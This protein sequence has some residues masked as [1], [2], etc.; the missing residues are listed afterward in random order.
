MKPV[1]KKI[2]Q[3]SILTVLLAYVGCIWV[4]ANR[5]A[6]RNA[7]KGVTIS[8]GKKGLSDT[9]TV[10]GVKGELMKYPRRIV[11][12]RCSAINTLD[13][14]RYLMQLNN[15]EN[16]KCFLSSSGYLNVRITPLIP[17]I[18]VFDGMKSYYVNRQGKRIDSK[19]EFYADVPLVTGRF[20]SAMRPETVLPVVRHINGHP[21]L[22]EIVAMYEMR[23]PSDILIIPRITGHVINFGDTTRLEEKCRMILTAYRKIIPYKGWNEYDTISVKF[24]GQIVATRRDKA[25]LWP[26]EAL[27]EDV[28]PEDAT[29]PTEGLAAAPAAPPANPGNAEASPDS[30]EPPR[31]SGT[32]LSTR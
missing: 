8:M 19:A 26:I 29:L 1:I 30:A 20:N 15:F 16:V 28:D 5:E 18:R 27:L 6:E 3:W 31:G 32:P 13:I 21:E 22:R 17:E 25:P 2:L 12:A 9:I 11:G 10:R 24:K 4:W 14:E 7:C 23:S